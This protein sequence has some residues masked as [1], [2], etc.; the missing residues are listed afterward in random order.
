MLRLGT[1]PEGYIYPKAKRP[2][3]DLLRR[4][5]LF[6]HQRTSHLLSLQALVD[7]WTGKRLAANRIKQVSPY[8]A[9]ALFEAPHL[10]L[11]ARCQVHTIGFLT[12]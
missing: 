5:M 1:L 3:R 6:L 7:R 8:A 10:A 9:E 12:G 2:T 4:R 11:S